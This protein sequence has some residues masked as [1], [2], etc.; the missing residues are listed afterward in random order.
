MIAELVGAT[1]GVGFQL[2]SAQEKFDMPAAIAWTLVL[3][4]FLLLSQFSLEIM[5]KNLLKYRPVG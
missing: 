5:E 3:V 1:T 2:L 4:V